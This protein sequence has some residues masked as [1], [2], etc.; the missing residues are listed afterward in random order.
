[1]GPNVWIW[2]R[3][4]VG[5]TIP[6]ATT[7]AAAGSAMVASGSPRGCSIAKIS[8]AAS[9]VRAATSADTP[10]TTGESH[11]RYSHAQL[12]ADAMLRSGCRNG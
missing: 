5:G 3:A 4:S 9:R 7:I 8:T 6:K 11:H 10:L 12:A 2:R 1:M